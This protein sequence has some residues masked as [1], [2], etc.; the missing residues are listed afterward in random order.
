MCY[1][2]DLIVWQD[3]RYKVFAEYNK[4]AVPTSDCNILEYIRLLG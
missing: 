1:A 4:R 3:K 2:K